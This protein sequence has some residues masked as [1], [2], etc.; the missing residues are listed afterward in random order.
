MGQEGYIALFGVGFDC[1]LAIG[2]PWDFFKE[3]LDAAVKGGGPS[4]KIDRGDRL[5]LQE[6][7]LLLPLE[8]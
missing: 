7:E 1:D 3:L 6:G 8:G 2:G 4:A 5:A